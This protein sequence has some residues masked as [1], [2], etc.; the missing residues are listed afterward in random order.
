MN[1]KKVFIF[2]AILVLIFA[3]GFTGY[4]LLNKKDYIVMI[5]GEK[6]SSKEFKF[7]LF[8]IKTKMEETG[9]KNFDTIIDGKKASEFAKDKAF[10]SI[11]NYELELQ[12]AKEKG[13]KLSDSEIKDINSEAENIVAQNV[14]L[15]EGLDSAGMNI[16]D[17]KKMN[18]NFSIIDK[19]RQQILNEVYKDYYNTY[20]AKYVAQ[21]EMLRARHI[22]IKTIDDNQNELPAEKIA[23]Q[24]KKAEDILAKAKTGEDFASLVRQYSEDTGSVDDGG[25]YTFGKGDMV[26]EFEA[27]AY[28]LNPGQISDLV[29]TK[30]G[31]HIIKLEERIPKGQALSYEAA[32]TKIQEDIDEEAVY[33]KFLDDWKN[34]SKINRNDALYNSIQ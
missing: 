20:K 31:F 12:K 26:P 1:L 17:F 14:T 13:I 5:N 9:L 24:K 21:D 6:A 16:E 8:S 22:L 18:V 7:M 23:E 27:A 28:S 32:L 34:N 29:K 30:F 11:V 25:E 15:K 10:E 2:T 19:L 33:E 3:V 4:K